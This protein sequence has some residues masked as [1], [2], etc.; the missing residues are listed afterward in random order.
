MG[1]LELDPSLAEG[2]YRELTEKELEDLK[3]LV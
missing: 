1:N 3:A 2:E